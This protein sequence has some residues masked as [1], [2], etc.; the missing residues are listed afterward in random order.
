MLVF[1]NG[2]FDLLHAGHLAALQKYAKLGR[3][4]TVGINSDKS[5]RKIKGPNRPILNESER[6][7]ALLSCRYVDEVH[8]FDEETALNLL[9]T[10]RPDI[11]VKGTEY[12]N[13]ETPETRWCVENSVRVEYVDSG[14]KLSTSEIISRVQNG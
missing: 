7:F 11:Y 4:L 14:S 8:I 3:H 2:C 9:M 1:T 13:K 12:I 6:K 10:I 5:V